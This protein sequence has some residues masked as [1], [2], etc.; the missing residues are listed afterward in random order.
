MLFH[1]VC[2]QE[3]PWVN[4]SLPFI[5]PPDTLERLIYKTLKLLNALKFKEA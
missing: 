4:K 2:I 5:T 3:R 1:S